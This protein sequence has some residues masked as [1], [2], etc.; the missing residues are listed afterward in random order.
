MIPVYVLHCKELPERTK[1]CEEHLAACG[2]SATWW[3][4]F[5]SKTWG[6]CTT[7][8][9]EPGQRLPVGHV[10]LNAGTWALWQ[11]LHLAHPGERADDPY[12]IF[13]DDVRL[14][15][16]FPVVLTDL[17]IQLNYDMPDWDLVFLG[18]AEAIPAVWHK[19]TERIGRPDSSLCRLN[20][21]FG[22]HAYMVRRRAL[23]VLLDNMAIA[24]RNLDQQLWERVLKPGK[25][26]WCARLP[27]LVE[28]RTFDYIGTG[29]PE[30]EPSCLGDPPPPPPAQ[31][32][33]MMAHEHEVKRMMGV[34]IPDHPTPELLAA[35]DALTDPIPCIYRGEWLNVDGRTDKG[36]IIPLNQ[37]GRMNAACYARLGVKQVHVLDTGEEALSCE[38]C[39]VR[40]SM[41]VTSDR[42]RFPVPDG[43]FNPS[44]IV[45]KDRLILA[46]RDSWGHSKV[47]LWKLTNS[48]SDWTGEWSV[49]PIGSFGSDRIDTPRLEDPRLFIHGD[50][51]HAMFN[52]PDGYPPV[53]VRVGF[54]RFAEDFSGIDEMVVFDSP[55]DC[56]YEKNWVPFSYN[57]ELHWVYGTKPEHVVLGE[58]N[59]YR[60]PNKLPWTGGVIRGGAAPVFVPKGASVE[61]YANSQDVCYHFFHGCL[62]RTRGA[63]YTM[64]CS[65]F[66]ARPPFTV[67]RQTTTPLIW[68]DLAGPGEHVVKRFIVWPG[69]AVP[70]AGR[71]WFALGI[72]DT[73]VRVTS[74]P[75]QDVE[76]SLNATPETGSGVTSIRET[77]IALGIHKSERK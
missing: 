51:L 69:G 42:E 22:T 48:H 31:P 50:R 21:P 26:Q 49:S 72:D 64:G 77:K 28:Q 67:L 20:D 12:V 43:H 45:Y 4:S 52:L 11:H 30:W 17:L 27:S 6:L 13:E 68:P 15:P 75:F 9:Y 37:C 55:A 54:C 73:F 76:A 53:K 58:E 36:R 16:N 61:M 18:L 8:E 63:V 66:E 32:A 41:S 62:K 24:Q 3:R 14:P 70:H 23:P 46:T 44:M 7:L 34:E 19:V 57:G 10:G 25:L 35:S 59:V 71:W 47:A 60:T 33:A 5:H 39:E 29:K 1:A 65:V 40:T 2:V 38:R 74:I 56:L